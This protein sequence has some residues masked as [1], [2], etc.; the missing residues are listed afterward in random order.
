[1]SAPQQPQWAT[2]QPQWGAAAPTVTNTYQP[3]PSPA[4]ATTAPT[5]APVPASPVSADGDVAADVMLQ[6]NGVVVNEVLDGI[7]KPVLDNAELVVLALHPTQE[8]LDV[9]CRNLNLPPGSLTRRDGKPL[10]FAI[11]GDYKIPITEKVPCVKEQP[12]SFIFAVPNLFVEIVFPPY[13]APD[14]LD[15]FDMVVRNYGSMRDNSQGQAPA[16]YAGGGGASSA[17]SLPQT[18]GAMLAQQQPQEMKLSTKIAG[19]IGTASIFAVK[20]IKKGA[21]LL[22]KGLQVGTQKIVENTKAAEK[23]VVVPK[24]AKEHIKSLRNVSKGAV[25]VSSGL[26]ASLIGVTSVIGQGIG[27]QIAKRHPGTSDPR[28]DGVKEVAGAAIGGIGLVFVT[29]TDAARTL[30]TA[31][32]DGVSTIVTHKMGAEAGQV[33]QEGLGVVQDVVSVQQNLKQVGVKAI[34]KKTGQQAATKYMAELD[35]QE[36]EAEAK[37]K[38]QGH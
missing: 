38:A 23:P 28:L 13:I 30:L 6:V 9:A 24:E 25:M 18:N 10:V 2:A 3:P 34:V 35:A 31:S 29:A 37:A 21:E 22:G 15:A 16:A 14:D 12:N 7:Q 19:G 5:T 1:M 36:A 20:G 33:T 27:A 26:A 17:R 4:T 8:E 11:A 32:C